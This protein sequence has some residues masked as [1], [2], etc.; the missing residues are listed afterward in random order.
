MSETG[1]YW[2]NQLRGAFINE[3]NGLKTVTTNKELEEQTKRLNEARDKLLEHDED[4]RRFIETRQAQAKLRAA[5][6]RHKTN[7]QIRQSLAQVERGGKRWMMPPQ[8]PPGMT[9]RRR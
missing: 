1:N 4:F 9:V 7:I 8:L 2:L 5:E 3:L 6:K